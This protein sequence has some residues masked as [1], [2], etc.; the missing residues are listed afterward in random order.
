MGNNAE[1]DVLEEEMA[2]AMVSPLPF[3]VSLAM[4]IP[5]AKIP[6]VRRFQRPRTTE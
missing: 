4:C 2:A 5:T 6:G 3:S 1:F